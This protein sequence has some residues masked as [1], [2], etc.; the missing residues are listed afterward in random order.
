M[1][2]V[3]ELYIHLKQLTTRPK[4]QPKGVGDLEAQVNNNYCVYVHINKINHKAYVGQTNQCPEHRWGKQGKGYIKQQFYKAIL[5]YGWDNFDHIVLQ[6][7]L[8]QEEANE[9]EKYY[10][11]LYDSWAN[12]YNYTEGGQNRHLTE[13]EKIKISEF[14]KTKQLGKNNSFAKSVICLNTQQKFD[15]LQEASDWCKVA[16]ENIS[17]ACKRKGTSGI[18]PDTKEPLYWCLFENYTNDIQNFFDTNKK[19]LLNKKPHLIREVEQIDLISGEVVE[20]FKNCREAAIIVFSDE[21]KHKGIS[22]C[23]LGYR[24]KAYGFGW[25]YKNE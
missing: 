16:P 20:I 5:K 21:K 18:H 24:N 4:L 6:T 9:K 8:T 10:I 3:R 11:K 13:N 14:M 17:G 7:N 22:R 2:L 12:G 15:T 19:Q 23:A 25:R 1:C